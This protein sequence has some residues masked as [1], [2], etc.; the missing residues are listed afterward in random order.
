MEL[1]LI[2]IAIFGI[3]G[4][5][6]FRNRMSQRSTQRRVNNSMSRK[7]QDDSLGDNEPIEQKSF[8]STLASN[9]Y[10]DSY[11]RQVD[12]NKQKVVNMGSL[13]LKA[14]RAG[15]RDNK[16]HRI[17]AA[18]M[19]FLTVVFAVIGYLLPNI[20]FKTAQP[21]GIHL[22]FT[23]GGGA[24]GYF[25]PIIRLDSMGE[26]RKGSFVTHFPDMLDLMTVCVEAGMAQNKLL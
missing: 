5:V 9:E 11:L 10:A 13:R 22:A 21:L 7:M 20:L 17:L 8:L 24:L 14:L 19:V 23:I 18:G 25:F 15:I 6:I 16:E 26:E 12:F 2:F 4:F 3:L 1:F